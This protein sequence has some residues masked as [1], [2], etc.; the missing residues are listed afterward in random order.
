MPNSSVK[1]IL[2]VL[3]VYNESKVLERS[4]SDLVAHLSGGLA[5]DWEILVADNASTDGTAAVAKVLSRRYKRV[6][7]MFIKRKGRGGALREAWTKNAAD[8][9]AYCDIDLA[10]EPAHLKSMFRHVLG[11]ADMVA[12]NRYS[13]GASSTRTLK[14][15]IP[16]RAYIFLVSLFF[17]TGITDFQCGFK[18][19]S[20]RVVKELLP[21]IEDNNWFFD[22]ELLIRAERSGSYKIIQMPVRWKENRKSSVKIIWTSFD[23]I[24]DLFRLK[25]DLMRERR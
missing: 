12:G 22:T 10:T 14:R 18:A 21:L 7:Y 2:L 8:V 23:Y 24:L 5:T 15:L 11:G 19:V 4:V 9:Y 3:P 6:R 25:M 1:T 13:S 20:R 16:S 17:R